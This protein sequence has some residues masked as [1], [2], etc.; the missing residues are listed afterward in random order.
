[1]VLVDE[2]L[3]GLKVFENK[4]FFDSR[5]FFQEYFNESKSATA[6]FEKHFVQA[7]HS[8]SLPNVVRGLHY[9]HS[10]NQGKLVGV[11]RGKIWDVAVDLRSGSATRG[12]H[13]ALE[14]SEENNRMLWVPAGFAHGFC[15]LGQEAADV[16][17]LVDAPYSAKTE[18]GIVWNDADL[19]IPWPVGAKGIV[20]EKDQSQMSWKEYV[21][22][23]GSIF[24]I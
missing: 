17:Y 24:S 11:I 16:L 23:C 20:S 22:N 13:F 18:G 2:K 1:M 19:K 3:N 12:Q 5:G 9:Q 7:N 15:V 14:L 6:G 4:K 8:R 10:P 21:K